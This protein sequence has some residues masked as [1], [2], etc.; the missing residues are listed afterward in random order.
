MN[1]LAHLLLSDPTPEF[2]VGNVLADLLPIG[3]LRQLPVGFQAGIAQHRAIDSFTDKHPIFRQSVARLDVRYRRY[4][5]VIMDIFYDHLLTNAWSTYSDA[6]LEKFVNDFHNDVEA[7]RADI[8]RDAYAIFLH[9]RTGHWLQSYDS[10][11]GVRVTLSRVSRRLRRP[12]DLAGAADQLL[13]H[14]T[15]LGRDFERFFPQIEDKFR[16]RH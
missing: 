6:P 3:Q 11:E 5:P 1:W 7:V 2:R 15:D 8:P 14:A 9:M 13:Q 12:F 4:G 16:T 10:V